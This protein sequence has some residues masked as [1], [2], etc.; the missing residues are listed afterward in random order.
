MTVQPRHEYTT[1]RR[2]PAPRK[3]SVTKALFANAVLV[4]AGDRTLVLEHGR[5]FR[6]ADAVHREVRLGLGGIP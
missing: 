5:R 4:L 1:T 3:P 6:E 2:L